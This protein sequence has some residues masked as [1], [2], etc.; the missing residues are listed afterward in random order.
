MMMCP[1]GMRKAGHHSM[2]RRQPSRFMHNLGLDTRR[3]FP[4]CR[5]PTFTAEEGAP[6]K[7]A[8]V[9]LRPAG[10]VARTVR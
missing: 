8:G 6:T 3:A 5:D 9:C 4:L 1:R 7:A 2:L 10:L